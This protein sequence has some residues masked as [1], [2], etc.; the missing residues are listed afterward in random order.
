MIRSHVLRALVVVACASAPFTSAAQ[1]PAAAAATLPPAR[2]GLDPV[3]VPP[4]DGLEPIVARHLDEVREAFER[5]TADAQGRSG[6]LAD[7]YSALARV[8]HAYEFLESAEAAYVNA[9]RLAPG[10]GRWPHLLGYLYQQTGRLEQ[11]AERLQAARRV[12][13][14]DRAITVRLADVYLGLNRL[15]EARHEFEAVLTA[16]P[17]AA[18]A[19]LGEVALREGRFT[20]AIDHFDA[21]LARVPQATAL[22]YPLAMAYR[23]LGR[24][25]EAR[26]HLEKRGSG[27]VVASDPLTD[28]LPLL[29]RG[30]RLL[31]IQGTRAYTAG[32]YDEAVRLFERALA[33]APASVPARVNLASA[34][35]QRGDVTRAIEQL[36]HA[37]AD[38]P[39]DV[40]PSIVSLALLLSEREQYRDA[41]ALLD[42]AERRSPGRRAPA[43]LLARLLASAPQLALRDGT[44][45]LAIA[46]AVQAAHA[47]PADAE[48]MA[49]ALAELGRCQEALNWMRRAVADAERAGAAAE[50]ARLTGEMPAYTALVCRRPGR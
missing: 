8:Y 30:E 6:R 2:S 15:T 38:A 16:F 34:L 27:G 4:L 31:V 28:E 43:T 39:E 18:R 21:A 23:G 14:G 5:V 35:V 9:A 32:K 40:E 47:T 29:V 20:E 41:I 37:Y 12:R 22:H 46:T 45:A 26:A 44:R 48:T 50:A 33:A 19:G 11:A 3:P 13:P 24:L 1:E 36:Q 7:A 25:D 17:A 42:G 10:D 49:L